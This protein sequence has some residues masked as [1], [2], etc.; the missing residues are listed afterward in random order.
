[1]SFEGK[2]AIVTGGG[3]D[4]GLGCVRRLAA[5]GARVAV[6]YFASAAGAEA[7]VAAIRSAGGAAIAVQGDMKDPA[8]VARLVAETQAA[9]GPEIHVLMHVTG[10]IVARK[11]I[12]EM[13][14]A[15]FAEVMDLNVGSLFNVVKAVAPHMP[16][17]GAIVTFASQ[18]GRDGGGP[19]AVAYGNPVEAILPLLTE[20]LVHDGWGAALLNAALVVM[21]GRPVHAAVSRG[22]RGAMGRF[23]SLFTI[24]VLG[25]SLAHLILG[26]PS[27]PALIGASGGVCGL[28][29]ALVLKEEGSG[30]R[31]L[32]ARFLT[33][34]GV[35]A[36]VN[37]AVAVMGPSLLGFRMSWQ[38]HIGGFLAGAVAFAALRPARGAPRF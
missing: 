37:L 4:I 36:A 9:F 13:D 8:D 21:A 2:T 20:A 33:V 19:G 14:A 11:R 10:G 16:E 29:G 31:I 18:A 22:R 30:A 24:S 15:H 3:R 35:F 28:L 5:E 17:G 12:E 26:F 1:M 38:A 6:N 27:G 25:G 34:L 23:L 7:A 32:S